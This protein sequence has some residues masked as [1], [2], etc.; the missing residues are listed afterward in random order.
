MYFIHGPPVFSILGHGWRVGALPLHRAGENRRRVRRLRRGRG[1]RAILD[2]VP[3][4]AGNVRAGLQH[5]CVALPLR[6][7]L[8]SRSWKRQSVMD[9]VFAVFLS[10]RA[11]LFCV[12]FGV[13]FQNWVVCVTTCC[14]CCR[15][16]DEPQQR[17]SAPDSAHVAVAPRGN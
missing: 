17:R 8:N 13:V 9:G 5:G 2:A 14:P 15:Q 6:C 11:L 3:G 10:A 4:E 1:Q 12:L 16:A 7:K